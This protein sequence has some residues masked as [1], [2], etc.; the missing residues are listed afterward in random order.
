MESYLRITIDIDGQRLV[1]KPLFPLPNGQGNQSRARK[2]SSC[3]GPKNFSS[4]LGISPGASRS[5]S[6]L[7]AEAGKASFARENVA[8]RMSVKAAAAIMRR[9]ESS[10]RSRR[11]PSSFFLL[12]FFFFSSFFL[13]FFLFFS[14]F[15][16]P[17]R[18]FF[19]RRL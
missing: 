2:S 6:A 10:G 1:L 3:R 14:Y 15:F 11:S 8:V 5:C 18:A 19:T 9:G 12:F 13:I 16:F 4:A 7:V 17:P